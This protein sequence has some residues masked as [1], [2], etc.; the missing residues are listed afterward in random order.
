M[1]LAALL[2]ALVP[3]LAEAHEVGLSYGVYTASP[4]GLT[5]EITFAERELAM[6]A[7]GLDKDGDG[8]TSAAEVSTATAA[9]IRDVLDPVE[10][11]VGDTR[12]TWSLIGARR[13]EGDGVSVDGEA[14]CP[15][16]AATYALSLGFL[17]RTTPGH[18]HM[19]RVVSA[20]A[21]PVDLVTHKADR[22]FSVGGAGAAAS[23]PLSS[24]PRPELWAF[25]LGLLIV[26]GR[27]R[28]LGLALGAFAG[29]MAVGVALSSS[30]SQAPRVLAALV[31]V[32]VVYVGV[33]DQGLAD[34]SKRWM[35]GLGFGLVHGLFVASALSAGLGILLGAVVL[36]VVVLL[37]KKAWFR[38]LVVR[39]VGV[40]VA[41]V[42]LACLFFWRGAS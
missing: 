42:G 33:E 40:L 19:V 28:D 23:S 32:S 31:A 8:K 21:T 37:Q 41:C 6:L 18:R 24:R 5:V 4:G 35:V 10:V 27:P 7:D 14:R 11:R 20:G 30:F 13:V 1:K 39:P 22:T 26:G 12:C 25:V 15:A 17:D 36:G 16:G 38:R 34:A 29:G 3:A 2:L 9:L